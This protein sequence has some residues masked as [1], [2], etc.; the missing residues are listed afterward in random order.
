MPIAR[1]ATTTDLEP[2]LDLFRVSEVSSTVGPLEQAQQ[3]WRQTLGH[4]GVTVFVT[5]AQ[6]KIVATCM[7]IT[8]PNLLRSG[9]QHAFLENVV[10]HPHSKDKAMA[11]PSLR[12]RSLRLGRRVAIMSCFKAVER[13][14]RCTA[15][16]NGVASNRVYERPTSLAADR[17]TPSS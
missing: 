12:L 2:L 8:A 16:T 11:V 17:W 4:D 7:L 3:V 14:L 13:I 15:S 5:E 10:T 9:R 1:T 6:A